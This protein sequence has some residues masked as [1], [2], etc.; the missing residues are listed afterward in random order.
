MSEFLAGL[1]SLHG[2]VAIVTGGSRGIGAGLAIGLQ[3]AG[4]LVFALARSQRQVVKLPE[5]I[6]YRTCD[7][8]RDTD[9][10]QICDDIVSGQKRLDILVNAAGISVPHAADLDSLEHFDLTINTNLRAV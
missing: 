7:V 1:F 6:S 9:F 10:R 5:S 3:Q 8:T 2:K 4:A